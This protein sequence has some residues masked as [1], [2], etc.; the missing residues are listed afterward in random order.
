VFLGLNALVGQATSATRRRTPL[1][2]MRFNIKNLMVAIALVA[3]L[4]V[5]PTKLRVPI[6][7]MAIPC[8]ISLIA[9]QIWSG[10]YRRVALVGFGGL[11]ILI[12]VLYAITTIIP[13]YMIVS[14]LALGW[15]IVFL[16]SIGAMGTAWACLATREDAT[17]RRSRPL[18]WGLVVLSAM[19]PMIT[20]ATLWPLRLAFLVIRPS[21]E[22]LADQAETGRVLVFPHWI[23]PFRLKESAVD[24]A[25]KIV[26]LFV[27]PNPNGRTGF[28]K[29]PAGTSEVH[30]FGLLMGT[31]TNVELGWGWS[32][33]QDD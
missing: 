2:N 26:G 4:L 8:T 3:V 19:M 21:M 5:I 12:N 13:D 1:N 27:D 29:V 22:R 32:Y 28:V 30:R 18:F 7:V 16:P 17:P 11:S 25:S 20:L 31:D 10:R 33:R 6:C 24:P 23:G 15:T 9:W 14:A